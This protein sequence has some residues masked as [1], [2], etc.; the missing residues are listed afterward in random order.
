MSVWQNPA[1]EKFIAMLGDE[2]VIGEV[3]VRRGTAGYELCHAAD[4][5]VVQDQ[6][7]LVEL[8]GLRT[9]AQNTSEGM[10]RPLKA[11]P[12]L[13]EGWRAVARTEMD[14]E[15]A[16]NHLY[17]GAI[18]DWFAAQAEPPPV[19]HYREYTGRQTG[20]YR[21][22]TMLTDLQA[23]RMIQACCAGQFCLKRRLWTV[24]GLAPD[25][26]G[27]KSIIPCLEPCAVLL[28]FARKAARIEQE[29][30]CPETLA[31]SELQTVREAL[32]FV[33]S[34]P[35]EVEREADFAPASNLRRQRLVLE[36]ISAWLGEPPRHPSETGK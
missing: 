28:E 35:P 30:K 31:P 32:E 21:I 9:I 26:A 22:T 20:M 3:C 12:N 24:G 11:A 7:E 4:R 29:E 33:L 6:L 34:K 23:S 25:A 10:F 15:R 8:D 5:E 27:A 19:T 18:A 14:L 16:L 2:C 13:R 1:L 17:P 36:K